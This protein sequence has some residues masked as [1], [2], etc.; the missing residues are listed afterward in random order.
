MK[1]M[2]ILCA[3]VALAAFELAPAMA[4]VVQVAMPGKAPSIAGADSASI[5][6]VVNGQV[7]TD[8]DVVNRA[9]LLSLSTGMPPTPDVLARLKPQVTSQLIDQTL[10]M[11]EIN[12]RN[13]TVPDTDVEAAI[14]HIEQGNGLPPGGLRA[15]LAAAGIPFSTLVAQLRTELGWQTVLHQVLGP[16][17]APTKG[18]MNAE[19]AALKAELGS[20]QYH[21]SEIFVPVTD[22]ADDA[23]ARNFA[24]TVISQLRA[25]APFPIVAAQ[26]S[27][28][29]TALQGGD[30]GYVQMSQLDP[31]VAALVTTMPAGA[32]S[33]PVRVPGGYDIVQLQ[34]VHKF[35][36]E[37]QTMLSVRQAF[38]RFPTPITNGAVGPVQAAV[39]GKLEQ[40]A[41][42]A[43]SCTDIA[44][45]NASLGSVHPADPG[46]VNL[47]TVT[48]PA[49]Q[50]LLTQ[51]PIGQA[52]RPLVEGDGASVVMICGRTTEAEPLPSDQEIR[53]IIVARRVELESQQLLDELRH[54]SI[55]E[56][57]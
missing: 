11:Q 15:R 22:P 44:A 19:K 25:G 56:Q 29:P 31:A 16:G 46:P 36:A 12:Q 55:I 4:Q 1:Q 57:G 41:N 2:Q 53:N 37:Q 54:R 42:A 24:N 43:H 26:F 51:L 40:A 39:I 48:P 20:T 45:L 9:R 38:A 13:V 49:F 33:N 27:Q 30:L 6:A 47:A 52:S 14:A 8:Q 35:G 17:L 5:A 28:S 50:T 23:N 21:I 32:I 3:A 7:I 10:E 34:G 18:D